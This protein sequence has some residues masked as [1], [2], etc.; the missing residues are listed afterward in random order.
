MILAKSLLTTV[1]IIIMMPIIMVESFVVLPHP[2]RRSLHSTPTTSSQV[3]L[4]MQ[5]G[6]KDITLPLLDLSDSENSDEVITPLPSAHLPSELSTMH[7]YGMELRRPIHK[8]LIEQVVNEKGDGEE[9]MYGYIVDKPNDDSLVG[10]VGCAAE[11]LVE[12]RPD[13]T[14]D[15]YSEKGDDSPVV[16][17]CRGSYRFKVKE[18]TKTFPYPVAIVDE[19]VDKEVLSDDSVESKDTY[20]DSDGDDDDDELDD[21]YDNLDTTELVRRLMVG[22]KTLIDQKLEGIK[23]EI[24]P[25]EQSIL[26]ES[27]QAHVVA[28]DAQQAEEMAAVFDIFQS[29]LIDIAPMPV[30]RYYAVGMLA[31]EM[32]NVDNDVR[33]KLI[34]MV[35]GVERMRIVLREVEEEVSMNQARRMAETITDEI[36]ED[37]KDLK[38]SLGCGEWSKL[39]CADSHQGVLLTA[40]FVLSL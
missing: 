40:R 28:A 18:V 21:T 14:D 23:T 32:A 35:D 10:A 16:V 2:S 33:R 29:S 37:S 20:E 6:R 11:V 17:L 19:V 36:D 30:D 9:R 1:M 31:A 13:N 7:L 27:G 39:H 24:S 26:E 3:V 12:A 5:K 25:L 15:N 22:L 38:V 4:A 8:M 34:K